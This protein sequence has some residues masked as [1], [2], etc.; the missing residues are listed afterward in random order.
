MNSLR[1]RAL[2]AGCVGAVSTSLHAAAQAQRDKRIKIAYFE[3]YRPLSFREPQ[4]KGVLV[5]VLDEVLTREM[6][7]SCLHE[8]YPWPRAQSLVKAGALDAMCTIATPERLAYA[9]A[10]TEPVVTAP[11]CVY[12]DKDN[13]LVPR[14]REART[15]EQLRLVGAT[16]LSYSANGW[17]TANLQGFNVIWGNDF[18]SALRML[19]AGR[20]DVMV[21]NALTM[22]YTL[23]QLPGAERVVRL[24]EPLDVAKFKLLIS[25]LSPHRLIAASFSEALHKYK[26]SQRY[27]EVFER[28]GVGDFLKH[29][30]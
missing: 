10:A 1:R 21:E 17:A 27:G 3:T 24:P 25:K 26:A 30:R 20:G 19:V 13:P 9:V 16:V 15:L 7:L 11:T 8:G 6:G 23:Q 14:L 5:D 18:M 29:S 12:V 28:Y 4:L 2:L 22:Q